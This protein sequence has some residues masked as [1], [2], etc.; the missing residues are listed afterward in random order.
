MSQEN[1]QTT[2]APQK[3]LQANI[4]HHHFVQVAEMTTSTEGKLNFF[5]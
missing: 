1:L 5:S 3:A 2:L 4:L